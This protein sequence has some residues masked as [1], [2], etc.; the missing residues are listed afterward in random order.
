MLKANIESHI[1]DNN[2]CLGSKLVKYK[3]YDSM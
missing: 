1:K 3:L 2:V